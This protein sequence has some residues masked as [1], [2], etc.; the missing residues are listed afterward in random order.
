MEKIFSRNILLLGED[1]QKKI[2]SK[3]VCVVGLGGV[4][5]FALESLVRSGVGEV[6]IVDFDKVA[7]SNINRQI[8]ALNST[9]GK[10]KTDVFEK[11]L[12]DIN[13]NL[14]I[15]KYTSFYNENL[16]EQIFSKKVDF[17]IDAI[18]IMSSKISLLA[19]AYHHKIPIITSL[20]AGNIIDPTSFYIA[21][22]S[23][24]KTCKS[25]FAKNVLKN[26]KKRG[27]ESNITAVVN[28]LEP[29]K[30]KIDSKNTQ[31]V[32]YPVASLPFAPAV[33]GYFM[34]YYVLQSFIE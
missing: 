16:N 19:Y 31:I 18:D 11:R 2:L 29:L 17:I 32:K 15:R 14:K 23:D 9:V 3:H 22:I 13:P 5:G 7:F 30:L 10:L 26:L 8:I 21:D 34:G 25:K 20:G 24:I 1:V 33:A 27:I 4:G 12:L 28:Q 6:S